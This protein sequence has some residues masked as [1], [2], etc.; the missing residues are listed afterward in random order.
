MIRPRR[1]P[2]VGLVHLALLALVIAGVLTAAFST[3]AAAQIDVIRGK[4]T[5]VEGLPLRNVRVTATSIPGNVTREVRSNNQGAY[6]IAFPGGAGDYI[7]GF[8]L[9]GYQFRQFEIKRVVDEDVLIAD[10]KLAVV[11]LDTVVATATTAQRINRNSQTP[12]VS[13]TEKMINANQLPPELQGD[14]AAMAASLPGVTLI[15]GL[16]GAAD[17]FSVLGLGADQNNTTLNGLPFN[18]ANLPRD[19][20]VQTSLTTSPYDASKG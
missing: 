16:D 12:D 20:P 15:P 7:M 17:G 3:P 18:S 8:A 2:A 9:V 11:Q 13:G 14:L 5:T 4:V 1:R 6:Q 19:A 10:A